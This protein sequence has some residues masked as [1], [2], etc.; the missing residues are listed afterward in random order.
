[1]P[2]IVSIR[3]SAARAGKAQR[4]F[5]VD[6]QMPTDPHNAGVIERVRSGAL[7]RLEVVYS[8]GA[9]GG[10]GFEDP[11]PGAT[12]EP[13][14]QKLM[15]VNDDALG[16]GYIG[17][18]DIHVLDVVLRAVGSMPVSAHGWGARVRPAPHG[19]ALDTLFVMF[20]FPD[21]TVWNHQSPKGDCE[22]WFSANG[23]LA[24]AFQG[25]AAS[26]RAS[27]WGKAHVRGGARHFPGGTV[28]NLYEAGAVRN[29]AAFHDRVVRGDVTNETVPPAIDSAL[30][31]VLGREAA[32][33]RTTLTL[34]QVVAEARRLE[35]DLKGL[36]P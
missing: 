21:G 8:A 30:V 24:A 1:V 32:G 22:P 14:M 9:V 20:T 3:E 31:S 36:R 10:K 23:S 35:V 34:D 26:A 13:R 25:S 29:I 7:G 11:P 16:C 18:Y 6:Y 2:G 4:V 27:Y 5:F 19:D 17:N 28:E 15:W 12:L 33:R